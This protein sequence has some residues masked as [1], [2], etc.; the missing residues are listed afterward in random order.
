MF[1]NTI[2]LFVAGLWLASCSE[3]VAIQ[4]IPVAQQRLP[5]IDSMAQLPQPLEIIDWRAMAVAYDSTVYDFDAQGEYWPLIWMDSTHKNFN[6]PTLG[7]Y[8]AMGD[9][10]QGLKNNKGMFHE[11]LATMGGVLGA[12]LVGIDKQRQD[13][14]NYVGMLR[15]YFNKDNGWNIMMNNTAPEVALLGGGYGR[16]WW[17]DVYPNM[18]F[19]AIY[20]RYPNEAG[21]D[22]LARRIA[23]QFYRADSVLAGNYS[24]TFFDY[25]RMEPESNWICAQEDAAAGHAWVLYAAYRKFGDKRYL[26]AAQ[27]AQRALESQSENRFYE[28]LMPYGAYTA[29]RMNA[30]QGTD[31]DVRKILEWTFDGTSVCR[32]GWGV[33]VGQWNGFDI[34]GIVGSTV[35]H[36]GYGFLMNTFDTAIPLVPMV[37]Y[38][39]SYASAIGK[40]MLH[41]ANAA[42]LFY[43]QYMPAEHQTIPQLAAT[44]KGVIGYE[45][46][47]KEST[48]D[49]YKHIPAPVAQGDGPNWVPGKNPEVSQFSVYGSAHAGVFGSIVQRTDVEG[50]LQL[51]L[52]ATDFFRDKAYPSYLCYNPYDESRE[53]TVSLPF[54]SGEVDLYDAVEARFVAHNVSRKAKVKLPAAGAAVLVAVPAG[55]EIRQEGGKLWAGDAV[56]DYRFDVPA[57]TSTTRTGAPQ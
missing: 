6:Q 7:L 30:E 14:M 25:A 33:L 37:R 12:T 11:S 22:T 56:I 54:K 51:D 19:Y 31:F 39:P 21:F 16:D 49:R 46:L 36:G 38:D 5:R 18:L 13:G 48:F 35:D 3:P 42:R 20:D 23:E 53:V 52:L 4:G 28:I 24:H 55:A 57:E 26:E 45:G 29:A 1:R 44:T 50:I 8:T 32:K 43:P 34:S 15:N 9:A 40:W 41:A 17:Y 27:R 47:V 10:R 2:F